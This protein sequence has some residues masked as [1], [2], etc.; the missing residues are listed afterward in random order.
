MIQFL[1]SQS[2]GYKVWRGCFFW[3]ICLFHTI[4]STLF[5]F[6][7]G[8]FSLQ[9]FIGEREKTW[10]FS[11]VSS[12]ET[13]FNLNIQFFGGN[14]TEKRINCEQTKA[15]NLIEWRMRF[16]FRGLRIVNVSTIIDY[17]NIAEQ[18]KIHSYY[19]G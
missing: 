3:L 5:A 15:A 9:C 7:I 11:T 10:I 4:K 19:I 18:Y 13:K 8:I 16:F 17:E 6:S 14:P 2:I 12:N 1:F